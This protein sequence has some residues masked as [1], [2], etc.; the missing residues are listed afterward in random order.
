MRR[1][2]GD[3]DPT[4]YR[5]PRCVDGIHHGCQGT[6]SRGCTCPHHGLAHHLRNKVR[7]WLR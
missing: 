2:Y 7:R 6:Y 5:T 1:R 3:Y 4:T